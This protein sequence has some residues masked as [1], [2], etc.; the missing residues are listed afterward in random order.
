MLALETAIP[1]GYASPI[2]PASG[3]ALAVLLLAGN[4]LWPGIWI[5]SAAA[6]LSIEGSLVSAAIIA[7]GSTVQALAGAALMRRHVGAGPRFRRAEEVV[8]FVGVAAL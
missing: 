5:G 3:V 4:R 1:P 8:K 7:T 2:W 6:N